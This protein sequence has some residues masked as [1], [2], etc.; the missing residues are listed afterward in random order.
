MI[1][2]KAF[3]EMNTTFPIEP[4]AEPLSPRSPP[5]ATDASASANS[6]IFQRIK[7]KFKRQVNTLLAQL[8][9]C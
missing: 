2:S 7:H 4:D 9:I 3:D 1:E 8:K 6:G 5:L